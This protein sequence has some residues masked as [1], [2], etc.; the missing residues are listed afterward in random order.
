[1]KRLLPV[2]FAMLLP[3][4]ASA[5]AWNYPA[6]QPP[7]LESREFNFGV[8]DAGKGGTTLLAQWR[9][10]AG[11]RSQFTLEAGLIAG[12]GGG[13]N[14]LALGGQYAYELH[15]ASTDVPLDFLLVTG[16]GL[17]LG[18]VS[19]L[20]IPVGVSLGY[21]IELDREVNL[22]PYVH[23]RLSLDV[24]TDCNDNEVGLGV[25]FDVGANLDLSKA[26]AVRAAAFFGG[27]ELF[28][29]NGIGLSVA[30]RPPGLRR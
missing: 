11:R 8:A 7:R 15:R 24:C 4:A 18:D 14:L 22:T 30:Y 29:R 26:I 2:L 25:N 1:M 21:R 3:V 16:A 10:L 28:G 5:Q 9:E 17:S 20:R 27:G 19:A 12:D 6:F 23:P 13:S